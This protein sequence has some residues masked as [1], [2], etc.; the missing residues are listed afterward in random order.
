MFANTCATSAGRRTN[1]LR[2]I[3]VIHRDVGRSDEFG[4]AAVV[5]LL[6]V[7][8]RRPASRHVGHHHVA[9][10]QT[11]DAEARDP[12]RMLAT[13]FPNVIRQDTDTPAT[14]VM[15]ILHYSGKRLGLVHVG[16]NTVT[17]IN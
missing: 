12:L 15:L 2:Q 14:Q 3:D 7:I 9:R 8:D 5:R 16:Y 10:V 13:I 1:R 6:A 4:T 11:L 17:P